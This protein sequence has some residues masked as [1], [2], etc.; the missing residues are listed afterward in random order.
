MN[1]SEENH[2]K[3]WGLEDYL[4]LFLRR[5][6]LILSIFAIVFSAAVYYS[7]TRPDVYYASTTFSIDE[8]AQFSGVNSNSRMMPYYWRSGPG[9]PLEYYQAIINSQP[10]R[11]KV[12]KKAF[13]DSAL[14]VNG[15]ISAEQIFDVL[16]NLSISKEEFST[17]LYMGVSAYDPVVAYRI[18]DIAANAFKERAGEVE[19]EQAKNIV[20]YVESQI[21]QAEIK[22]D[23]AEKDLQQFS[24]TSKF[25][26]TDENNSI[27]KRLNELESKITEIETQR[28][29]A[30]ANLET[31]N[32]QLSRFEGS[33]TPGLLD[34]ESEEVT[35]LRTRLKSLE[36]QR[37]KLIEAGEEG[38]YRMRELDAQVKHIKNELRQSVLVASE[39]ADKQVLMGSEESEFAVLRERRIAEELN[40][41]SLENEEKFYKTLRDNYIR[42][43]PNML[44][45]ALE[46]AKLQRAKTVASNLYSFLIQQGEEA[47]IR[48]AT[49]TGGLLIVSPPLM[50]LEP[51]PQNTLRNIFI[52][53]ILGLGLG[54]G[55]AFMLDMLDKSMRSPEDVRRRTGLT[56]IGTIPNL[57]GSHK[58]NPDKK[59]RKMPKQ[60]QRANPFAKDEAVLRSYL[61]LPNIGTKNPLVEAYR[62]LRTDLQFVNVDEPLKKLMLTSA[63][64]GE[65]KTQ[66][67]ANL[68]IS[69]SELGHNILIVDC[70]LRKP[71]QNQ[72]FEVPRSPG[73]TDYLAREAPLADIVKP[74]GILNLHVLPSG[75]TPPNPA[76]M[77]GS[78][79][80]SQLIDEVEGMYDFILFDTPPLIAVSDAKIL[81]PKIKNVLVVIRSGKTNYLIIQDAK[82]RL[83]NVGARLVGA[84]LN[85]VE[86]KKGYGYYYRYNYYYNNYYSD[87]KTKKKKRMP[88]RARV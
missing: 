85:G 24:K 20:D 38:S 74:T 22:L 84:V 2:N 75:T 55:A 78:N 48:A 53:L 68:A 16:G 32:L 54:F 41:Y 39:E 80:M 25:V 31:Y 7:L 50:P 60:K 77:L 58:H 82:E 4:S 56:V 67:T 86:T 3:E 34:I 61:L 33:D 28:Q 81:A 43:H 23:K 65:G 63:T 5:L 15:G 18:A 87:D 27:I 37:H 29:L 1:N 72:V 71:K 73:L 21:R 52:G 19:V 62:N 46:A 51:I 35:Q 47:K 36:D 13:S 76:E 6:G 42:Q 44:E 70:D 14:Q 12:L 88:R 49:G 11:D 59:H 66:T 30:M 26:I 9:K 40:V 57:E 69:Y 64:P 79:K 10:Y 45:D 83:K 8:Q 17:L